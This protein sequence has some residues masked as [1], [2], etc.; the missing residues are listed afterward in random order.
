MKR[1]FLPILAAFLFLVCSQSKAEV[2]WQDDVY[3]QFWYYSENLANF[4]YLAEQYYRTYNQQ[5]TWNESSAQFCSVAEAKINEFENIPLP[6]DLH[7]RLLARLTPL[8]EAT[9]VFDPSLQ[10]R[11][12]SDSKRA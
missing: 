3:H 5:V 7:D 2:F 8:V 10:N 9:V 1:F 6:G 11:P 12:G 4:Y